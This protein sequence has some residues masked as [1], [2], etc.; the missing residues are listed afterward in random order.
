VICGICWLSGN[1][2][3]SQEWINYQKAQKPLI[4]TE[5]KT[6]FL[7]K[8]VAGDRAD[9]LKIFGQDK[10]KRTVRGVFLKNL[11]HYAVFRVYGAFV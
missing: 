6:I 7:K 5:T 8:T 4:L 2:V 1:S 9:L 3:W 11:A 10:K